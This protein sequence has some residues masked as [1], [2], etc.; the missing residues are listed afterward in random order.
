MTVTA[1]CSCGKCCG[2]HRNWLLKPVYSSG[3]NKGKT[4]R[5]GITASGTKARHGTI[6]ADTSR[7]P[8]GTVM[9]IEG[10]GY[11]RVEDRGGAIKG[12]KIDLHFPS[13][14]KALEWG[15]QNKKVYVWFSPKKR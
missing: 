6:A 11:G 9:Y 1:Y 13:H 4:K 7:Y 2:W 5:V 3:P 12:N 14:K 8:F 15:R 10:Y